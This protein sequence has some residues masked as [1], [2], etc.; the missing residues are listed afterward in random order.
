[1]SVVLTKSR[2]TNAL[3]CYWNYALSRFG[4]VRISHMP[5]FVSVEPA[6]ICQLRCPECPVGQAKTATLTDRFTDRPA[7]P[8]RVQTFMSLDLF[9]R[10]LEQVKETAWVMQFFFQG[11]PLLNKDLPQMIAEAHAAGLYTIVSTNAQAITEEMA[12]ALVAA[13][14]DRIIVSM[15]GLTDESY[16]AYRIGGSLE[17]CKAAL[18]WLRKSKI[19]NQKSKILIELQCLRLKSNEHEWA[20]MKR[21]YKTLGADRLVFKTAQLYDYADGHPLMP[22][23]PRYSRYIQGKDGKY[24]RRQLRK[25][26]F[27]VWSGC[28]VTTNGDVLPCCYDKAHAHAYG[29]NKESAI[30]E[31]FRN[32]IS[33]AFRK[34]AIHEQP[35]ICK[36]CWK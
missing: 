1:M 19:K 35:D 22:S 15:D 5:L 4:L 32:A 13:G 27:R 6:A 9:R 14:L 36:E 34:A 18:R 30:G 2:C 21:V 11:E 28:V 24:H 7:T 12:Q 8:D 31:L 29:N 25:G 23:A 20:E 16:G 33:L 10:V 3:R 26:C 17:Q